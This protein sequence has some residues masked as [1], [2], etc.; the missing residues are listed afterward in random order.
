MK[1]RKKNFNILLQPVFLSS[2]PCGVIMT[3]N[4]LHSLDFIPESQEIQHIKRG[5]TCYAL[6][7]MDFK[8]LG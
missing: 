5:C 1:L 8:I 3:Q 2:T 6:A 7:S 4:M